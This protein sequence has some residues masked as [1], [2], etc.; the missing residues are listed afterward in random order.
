MTDNGQPAPERGPRIVIEFA[1]AGSADCTIVPEAGIGIGQLAAA[2]WLLDAGAREA[3]IRQLAGAG[4]GLAAG[5][6][7]L[8]A[9]LRQLGLEGQS[10]G[11]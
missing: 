2:S 3:R 8:G 9:L 10:N 1:A 4:P 6:P 5:V 11:G 7:D